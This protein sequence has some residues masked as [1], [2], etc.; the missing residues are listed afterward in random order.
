MRLEQGL[1]LDFVGRY[2]FW[3]GFFL[4]LSTI[5]GQAGLSG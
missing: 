4:R 3:H 2:R 5:G 1:N